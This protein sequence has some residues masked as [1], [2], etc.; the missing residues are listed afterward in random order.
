MSSAI[1]ECRGLFFRCSKNEYGMRR[2]RI[3]FKT[4]FSFLKR[5]SCPGCDCC[6]L[7]WDDVHESMPGFKN[8]KHGAIYRLVAHNFTYDFETGYVDGWDLDLVEVER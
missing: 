1:D 4:R 2:D 5:M 8:P 3:E 6:E 7:L